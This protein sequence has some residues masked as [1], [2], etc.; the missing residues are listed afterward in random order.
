M[1]VKGVEPS[2][3]ALR[4]SGSRRYDQVLSEKLSLVTAF[5]SPQLPSRSL[6]F[7]LDK[8]T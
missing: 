4:M 3:S 6:P 7:P 1:E 2:P 5:R 8:D